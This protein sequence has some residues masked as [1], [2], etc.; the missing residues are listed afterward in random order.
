MSQ[1]L[2][3]LVVTLALLMSILSPIGLAVP[4]HA[5]TCPGIDATP[6]SCASIPLGCPGTSKQGPISQQAKITC[7]Y[8]PSA[9]SAWTCQVA[10]CTFSN[11]LVTLGNGQIYPQAI[12]RAAT[13]GNCEEVSQCDLIVKYIDP[14]IQFLSALVGVAVVGSIII[15]GIQYSSSGGDPQKAAA[16]KNRIRDAIIA[17][18]TF[19]ALYALLNFLIPG[20]LV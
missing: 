5:A 19:I 15:G 8:P 6:T 12:D 11:P 17:L 16:A 14:L 3:R 7:P 2:K 10:Q 18:V 1:K 13:G 9:S 4:A 20:G